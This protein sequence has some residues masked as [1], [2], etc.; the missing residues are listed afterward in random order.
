M[1]HASARFGDQTSSAREAP[2]KLIA[3][4]LRQREPNLG[5]R[6][7]IH[8][9]RK[10]NTMKGAVRCSFAGGVF[11]VT[12]AIRCRRTLGTRV[13]AVITLSELTVKRQAGRLFL[14]HNNVG[15]RGHGTKSHVRKSVAFFLSLLM[16][17]GSRGSRLVIGLHHRF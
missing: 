17:Y 15:A 5:F 6:K 3:Q 10:W 11:E 14:H 8:S 9:Q 7:A 1:S 13:G 16:L 4:R 12:R 2:A